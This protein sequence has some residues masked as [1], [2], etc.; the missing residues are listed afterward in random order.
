MDSK[1][2][3]IQ[4]DQN[5]KYYNHA[6]QIVQNRMIFFMHLLL[7]FTVNLPLVVCNILKYNGVFWSVWIAIFWGCGIF[8][9]FAYVY[10]FVDLS[11]KNPM[12]EERFEKRA[13]LYVHI[14]VYLLTNFSLVV[15]N[16]IYSPDVFWAIY[17]ILGWGI[18]LFY[19]FFFTLVFR[20][21]KIKRWKQDK[22]IRL[23]KKYYAVDPFKEEA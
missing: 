19:H 23:M 2:R 18:G 7:Y 21:M 14:I 15:C 22:T 11:S 4:P 6:K 17:P 8:G 9:H 1:T 12:Q 13:L 10:I 20:G 3:K 16:R 5:L